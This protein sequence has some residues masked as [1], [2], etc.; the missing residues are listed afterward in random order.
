MKLIEHLNPE[1]ARQMLKE[2]N[3]VM[4]D[5]SR[6]AII[7]LGKPWGRYLPAVIFTTI[8]FYGLFH[9][10]LRR[11]IAFFLFSYKDVFRKC[12]LKEHIKEYS[13]NELFSLI[14]QSGFVVLHLI[15]STLSPHLSPNFSIFARANEFS[16]VFFKLWKKLSEIL[17]RY[18]LEKFC[19][20]F[21]ILCHKAKG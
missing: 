17:T 9:P 11:A 14:E 2:V 16:S 15:G 21:V 4:K 6:F 7:T 3:R 8:N 1:S 5:D 12:G 13:K 19:W 18:A 20:D 10:R